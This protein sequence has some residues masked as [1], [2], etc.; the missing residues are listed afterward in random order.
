LL[1]F[2]VIANY[3]VEY[4]EDTAL[5]IATHKSLCWVCYLD[6][7]FIIW[8]HAPGKLADILDCLHSVHESIQ[9]NMEVKERVTYPSLI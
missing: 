2:P 4:S 7:M 6:D 1:L 3:F 8:P 5:E 9:F